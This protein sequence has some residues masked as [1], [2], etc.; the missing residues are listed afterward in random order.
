MKIRCAALFL[1]ALLTNAC[2]APPEF[3]G[4]MVSQGTTYFALREEPAHASKWIELGGSV[5][6]YV[7]KSYDTLKESLSLT[8]NGTNIEVML[9]IEAVRSGPTIELLKAVI[10]KGDATRHVELQALEM[11]E[12]R[13]NDTA[14]KLADWETRLL[15]DPDSAKADMVVNLRRKLELEEANLEYYTERMLGVWRKEV[16]SSK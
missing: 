14:H 5:G 3:D 15:K 4:V 10:T 13:R 11:L 1:A 7:L 9:K 8:R 16:K 6:N 2:S 12:T